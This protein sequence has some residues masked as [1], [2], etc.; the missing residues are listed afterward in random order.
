MT[1][2][3]RNEKRF[4]ENI[5]NCERN[6]NFSVYYCRKDCVR[7]ETM[8]QI[9]GYHT[10]MMRACNGINNLED[11]MKKMIHTPELKDD[12]CMFNLVNEKLLILYA[13]V[14]ELEKKLSDAL[15]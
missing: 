1:Y 4:C 12:I 14:K 2:V 10:K 9:P 8:A 15:K 7:C 6:Y 3:Y 11:L 5:K 13:D